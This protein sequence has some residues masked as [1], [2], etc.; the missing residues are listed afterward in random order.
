[1]AVKEETT[2]AAT[3]GRAVVALEK[4]SDN[5]VRP[6]LVVMLVFVAWQSFNSRH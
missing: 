2:E 5:H 6:E 4:I 1:M 3:S